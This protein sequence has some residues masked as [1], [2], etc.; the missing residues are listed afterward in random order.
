MKECMM[1][2]VKCIEEGE[3]TF[4]LIRNTYTEEIKSSF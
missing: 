2:V 3:M 1:A 4:K